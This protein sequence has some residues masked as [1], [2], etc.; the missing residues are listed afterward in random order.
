MK[1][2]V[3]SIVA[4]S[5]LLTA[6]KYEEGPGISLRSKRDRA[7]N[8]WVVDN[9][10]YTPDGGSSEDRTAWYNVVSDTFYTYFTTTIPDQQT[11]NDIQ[12][13]DSSF[14]VKDYKHVLVLN[15]TGAYSQEVVDVVDGKAVSV[16]PR[17]MHFY[18]SNSSG[19]AN[20]NNLPDPLNIHQIGR[21]GD[22]SFI[23]KHGRLQLK[24]DNN[25]SN[26][27]ADGII[28]GNNV[29][30]IYDIIMLAND[31]MKLMAID[32]TGA[33]HEYSLKPLSEEKYISFKNLIEE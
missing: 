8:E 13:L 9:Y 24:P 28:A 31:N 17:D 5:V 26:F 30:V 2:I 22:W 33:K 20:S 29:P 10:T 11:G 19:R 3:Y 32:E 14:V 16:D 21:R 6:C 4:L 15:R 27:D 1:K 12:V 7:S 18:V 25:G 23:S